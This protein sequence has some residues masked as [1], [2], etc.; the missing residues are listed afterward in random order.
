[1]AYNYKPNTYT[2][3]DNDLTF[4][5]NY[6][7]GG[8]ITKENLDRLEDAVKKASADLSVA[9]T[10]VVTDP[11]AAEVKINFNELVGRKDLYFK[12]PQGPKGDQGEK[13]ETGAQGPQGEQ[14]VQGPQ[15]E[16]GPKGD[17]GEKW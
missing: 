1:M 16:V 3:Y 13:G 4:E 11:S 2:V 9:E 7:N 14:G 17:Q 15:G 10:E 12:I 5:E 8:V 6:Q